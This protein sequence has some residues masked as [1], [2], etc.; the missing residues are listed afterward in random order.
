VAARALPRPS[1]LGQVLAVNVGVLVVAFALVALTPVRV[2]DAVLLEEAVILSV[3]LLVA[4]VV[5]VVVVRRVFA[6][7]RRLSRFMRQVDPLEPGSRLPM[8][9]AADVRELATAFNDMLERLESERRESAR[10]EVLAQEAERRRIARELHDELGQSLTGVLL[11][12][13]AAA[14]RGD[15]RALD[16][17]RETARESLEQARRIA[18]DLR[19]DTLAELGL[20]SALIALCTRLERQSGLAVEW[21]IPPGLPLLAEEA[22]IVVYRVAQE[23]LTNVARHSGAT[24]AAL[25]VTVAGGRIELRV[26]DD[27]HGLPAAARREGRGITGMRERALLAGGRLALG[28]SAALGGAEVLLEIPVS[29]PDEPA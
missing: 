29:D 9:G 14:R 5:D 18:R 23:S 13:D 19:S 12:I 27:G 1:L 26:A 7:L 8:D 10:R 17:A 25:A 24:R 20:A 21:T 11:Q 2:T 28:R 22:E 3:I 16:E 15:P 4:G 6:P